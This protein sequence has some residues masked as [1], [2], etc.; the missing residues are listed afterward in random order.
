MAEVFRTVWTVAVTLS[1]L[2]LGPIFHSDAALAADTKPEYQVLQERSDRLLVQLPNR[3]IVIAQRLPTAPVVSAQVW[4]KTGSIYEQ[5]FIGAG[6]SHFLEHLLSGGSTTTRTEA[7][8]NAILGRIG[9]KTNAATG[10]DNVH[11]HIDTT[12]NHASTAIELLT[13]WMQNSRIEQAE[14]EREQQVIQREFEHG[15][16]DPGRIFWKLTQQARFKAHPARHP[17]I[18]Y[19]SDFMAVSRDQIYAFYKR[20][21]VPNNMVFVVAG[22]VDP[23]KTVNHI[24]SLWSD[25]PTGQLPNLT[26]PVE[27]VPTQPRSVSGIAAIRQPKLRLAWPGTALAEKGDYALDLLSS[28][29]GRGESSR[30]V[31]VVRDEKRLVNTISAYNVSFTWGKGFFGID[32]DVVVKD[33]EEP[34]VAIAR[35][36]EAILLEVAKIREKG[37]TPDEL[38]RA[39]RQVRAGVSYSGQSANGVAR[40]LASDVIG[41]GDPDY[42]ERYAEKVQHISEGQVQ[43]VAV[44][45]LKV[46]RMMTVTLM[47]PPPGE[48]PV[49]MERQANEQIPDDLVYEP[50]ILDNA[51]VLD[52]L[53]ATVRGNGETVPAVTIDPLQEHTLPNGLRILIQRSTLVPAVS[54]QMYHLGG[55]L[56]DT[57]GREGVANATVQMLMKGTKSRNA[58]KIARRIEDLGASF[59]YSC[60]NNTFYGRGICLREDTPTLLELFADTLLNPTFPQDEWAKLQPRLVAAIERSKESWFGELR[61]RFRETYYGDIHTWGQQTSGRADVVSSLTTDDLRQFHE[62]NLN[63]SQAVVAV[64]GDVDPT[65]VVKQLTE[66]FGD[67]PKKD[68]A[69]FAPLMPVATKPGQYVYETDKPLAAVQMGLGPGVTRSDPDYPTLAVLAN[70]LS[71]FP[72]GWLEAELRGKG[73]G[74]AYAAWA[75]QVTGVIPG[76]LAVGF[77]TQPQSLD[78]A[79]RRTRSVI[80]RARDTVV[81]QATLD[82][83][84]AAVLVREFL[85]K[86][87]NGDRATEASLNELYGLPDNESEQFFNAVNQLTAKELQKVAQKRLTNAVTVV[88]TG[89][90][91]SAEK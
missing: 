3:M 77:N 16:G 1:I 13:D 55:L 6:L 91:R 20:M 38:A 7:E 82:R 61:S 47:P 18:G 5:E 64:F 34:E 27:P 33:G 10:L 72:S 74:L 69:K 8:S 85:G 60:G 89:E 25:Q 52:R 49:A 78:E 59:G 56:A 86:Q 43:Y 90:P 79:I 50:V 71:S 42:M 45:F 30:L 31:R 2:L 66:L 35:A 21:Y 36:R 39:K 88:I 22:D 80:D 53:T 63:M 83:A 17:T 29:L 62:S 51:V 40:R 76:Y 44:E 23:K 28:A 54:I 67:V 70:V 46:E 11:Y 9:A 48:K 37:V 75:Y 32:A 4:V 19:L 84:K 73:P 57:P 58:Q 68:D 26:F 12:S 24:A 14:Y 65:A 87:S 81:D 41:M 15:L